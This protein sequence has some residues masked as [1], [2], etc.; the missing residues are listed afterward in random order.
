MWRHGDPGSSV[1]FAAALENLAAS[2]SNVP[3]RKRNRKPPKL[4]D[5]DPQ[6]STIA[7][8]WAMGYCVHG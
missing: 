3:A 2:S 4:K 6:V 1:I 8:L 7:P 5:L